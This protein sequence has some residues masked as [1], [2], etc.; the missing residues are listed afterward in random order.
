MQ[1]LKQ[2]GLVRRA[3][4]WLVWGLS[5]LLHL[6]ML[7]ALVLLAMAWTPVTR[8]DEDQA[9]Q[10]FEQGE[11]AFQSKQ[12]SR[13]KA[14][15]ESAL[16]E[17][18]HD[19]PLVA[20]RRVIRTLQPG[21][22]LRVKTE[23]VGDRRD[24]FPNQRLAAIQQHQLDAK[25]RAQLAFKAL[26]P[27]QLRLSHAL[28]QSDGD[29]RLMAGETV[30]L[31]IDISND[32]Q[33]DAAAVELTVT[34]STLDFSKSM[35]WNGIAAGER[36]SVDWVLEVPRSV[37]ADSLELDIRA[38]EADGYSPDI[39][40]ASIPL[41]PWQPPVLVMTALGDT[42]V[43]AGRRSQ[44]AFELRNTGELPARDVQVQ[45]RSQ[46]GGI[47][48]FGYEKPL[49]LGLLAPGA[50]VRLDATVLPG[51]RLAEGASLPLEW[52]IWSADE[53]LLTESHQLIATQRVNQ[54]GQYAGAGVAVMTA[55][56][57]GDIALPKVL[58][59]AAASPRD[60]A[61]LIGNRR[62]QNLP[63]NMS[64]QFAHN[65]RR[66]M[67]QLLETSLGVP[68]ANVMRGTEDMT[69]GQMRLLLGDG[70]ALGT[71]HELI[72]ASG[73]A[74]TVYFYYSGHGMPDSRREGN[75]Y[76]LPVDAAP[77]DA[78]RVGYALQTLYAQLAKLPAQ[79]VVVMLD[80]CFSGRSDSLMANRDGLSLSAGT[81]AMLLA[82]ELP[83][84]PDGRFAIFTASRADELANW[85]PVN[86][87]GLFTNF[88]VKGLAGEADNGD[89]KLTAGELQDYLQTRVAS[90]A[91]RFPQ[92]KYQTP[93]LEGAADLLLVSYPHPRQTV[94]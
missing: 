9:L 3:G 24:Y 47:E 91:L 76:L 15:Y 69:A 7:L 92:P 51:I 68:S 79:K 60:F 57:L 38:Q 30:R 32:S 33:M 31:V 25:A 88:L 27:P 81:S 59:T 16:A 37:Q 23:V 46:D 10:Y 75:A 83:A 50:A 56:A 2:K 18:A 58:P 42:A 35:H 54:D 84:R 36:Q 82:P 49:E 72:A 77:S 55:A 74:D 41:L 86:R 71:L 19:G 28:L 93:Q 8:A 17:E 61:V 12:W 87:Q 94:E 45:V 1:S 5:N 62:Y 4:E 11:Q 34:S 6:L 22:G 43:T 39:L 73:G 21:P 64:V 90:T 85:L 80:A 53:L 29:N 70:S 48:V 44:Q 78:G 65:D 89:G 26:T 14:F 66:A 20:N 63:P 52:R 40:L 13:A 67:Q